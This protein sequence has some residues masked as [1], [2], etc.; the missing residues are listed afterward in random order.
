MT[1]DESSHFEFLTHIRES[2]SFIVTVS[3]AYSPYLEKE[4]EI[5]SKDHPYYT[6]KRDKLTIC[7]P[8]PQCRYCCI[9]H[10]ISTI[11]GLTNTFKLPLFVCR[12]GRWAFY[13]YASLSDGVGQ[14]FSLCS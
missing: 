1:K 3:P 4:R 8:Q 14:S 6:Q 5:Y 9:A 7:V 13:E 10:V 11:Q 2:Q 12:R